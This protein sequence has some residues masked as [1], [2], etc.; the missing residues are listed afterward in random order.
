MQNIFVIILV[1]VKEIKI[2][3]SIRYRF[4]FFKNLIF[5][6]CYIYIR[7]SNW[8]TLLEIND[9][10]FFP[11]MEQKLWIF[12]IKMLIIINILK[13]LNII[14][15]RLFIKSNKHL[16]NFFILRSRFFFF[17][18]SYFLKQLDYL[19]FKAKR[20]DIQILIVW[21]I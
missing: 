6:F 17:I 7:R 18:I 8:S 3:E 19:I 9:I 15:L 14:N 11:M 13:F 10:L 21:F 16:C 12:Y 1:F 4:T 5:I 2:F 20:S